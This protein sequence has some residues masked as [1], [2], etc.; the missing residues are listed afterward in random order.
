MYIHIYISLSLR[1]L[2]WW[3]S[4]HV[5]GIRFKIKKIRTTVNIAMSSSRA[6][7]SI[8]WFYILEQ[9]PSMHLCTHVRTSVP[10]R[11]KSTEY[12]LRWI[13][14]EIFHPVGRYVSRIGLRNLSECQSLGF[15]PCAWLPQTTEKLCY[16]NR[17]E[18]VRPAQKT[19]ILSRSLSNGYIFLDARIGLYFLRPRV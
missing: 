2:T 1:W 10:V 5:D 4:F 9:S 15:S 8:M 19:T 14:V 6:P 11:K 17:D 7:F 18:L 12:S 3:R 13:M 16:D